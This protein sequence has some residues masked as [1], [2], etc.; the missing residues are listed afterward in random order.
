MFPVVQ[1][2]MVPFTSLEMQTAPVRPHSSVLTRQ[3]APRSCTGWHVDT[4]VESS[5]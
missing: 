1:V 5:Q 4:P 2:P 3:A